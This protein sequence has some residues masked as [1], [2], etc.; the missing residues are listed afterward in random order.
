[1]LSHT[2]HR[3]LLAIVAT[4]AALAGTAPT[5]LASQIRDSDASSANPIP[6]RVVRMQVD[7]G[8][9][10]GDAGIGAAGMLALVLVGFGGAHAIGSV[11]S[12]GRTAHS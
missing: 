5:A 7:S 8:L 1:M 2:H 3:P 4:A 6:V 9:D 10:W 12:R 11:P